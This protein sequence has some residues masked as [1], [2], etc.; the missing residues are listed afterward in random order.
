MTMAKSRN[1]NRARALRVDQT[2]TEGFL[3]SVLRGRRLGDWKWKRQVPRG[4]Y[5]VDFYCAEANLAV[6]LDGSQHRAP[7]AMAY[8]ARRTVYLES[9]G[10]RVLRIESGE[11][12]L[13]L[14]GVCRDILIAC[15]GVG[16]VADKKGPLFGEN[17]AAEPPPHPARSL[18]S[19]R[20]KAGP[21][22]ATFSPV[23]NG[24]EGDWGG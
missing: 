20:P 6:E 12:F 24:G 10:V 15:G 21:G 11:V 9:L 16:E 8:D 1:R 18:S 13:N 2:Q 19:G 5:I 23:K 17:A 3:W 22:G 4:P 14:D 7:N